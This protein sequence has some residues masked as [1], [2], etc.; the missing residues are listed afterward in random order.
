MIFNNANVEAWNKTFLGR[1]EVEQSGEGEIEED[2][3]VEKPVEKKGKW[4]SMLETSGKESSV[5][6]N[7]DEQED[8]DGEEFDEDVDGQAMEEEEDVDGEVMDE[9][10]DG[11]PMEEEDADGQLTEEQPAEESSVPSP[12][13]E[14]EPLPEPVLSRREPSPEKKPAEERPRPVKRQRMKAA[15][16]F[17]D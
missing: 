17:N 9:D 6:S 5:V 15:D 4:K 7:I 14:T 10:I 13:P 2:E 3:V 12:L 16:M 1:N 8:V 11:E